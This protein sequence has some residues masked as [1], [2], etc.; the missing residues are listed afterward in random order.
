MCDLYANTYRNEIADSISKFIGPKASPTVWNRTTL[1]SEDARALLDGIARNVDTELF[2]EAC[3]ETQHRAPP[4]VLWE[5][6]P[7]DGA[8]AGGLLTLRVHAVDVDGNK[9]PTVAFRDYPD[10]D[11]DPKND[12]ATTAIDTR[13]VTIGSDDTLPVVVIAT[14]AAGNMTTSTRTFQI[15]NKPPSVTLDSTGLFVDA[16][17]VWWTA[18]PGPTLHGTVSDM[19][20]GM[21]Q[22]EIGG[23][24]VATAVI[25]G[26][27][28][29]AELP[30]DA[31][32][33]ADNDVT[34]VA[35]DAAGN[36]ATKIQTI[37]LD[38][39]P[40]AISV[41]PSP[42]FDET[43]ST[44]NPVD[45]A[46]FFM[47]HVPH[48]NPVDLATTGT[49]PTVAKHA[50]LLFAPNSD[51][52][53]AV[54]GSSGA[55]NPLRINVV[56]SDDGVG[57]K[58]NSLQYRVL[59]HDGDS[60]TE[61]FPWAA[62]P[63]AS[64]SSHPIQLFRDAIPQLTSTNGEY[65]LQ[66]QATD[67]FGRQTTAERCWN[68]IILAPPLLETSSSSGG[69]KATGFQR[70]LWSTRL[71]PGM[72]ET[73]DFAEKF[74]N[75]NAAGAAVW[76]TRFKNYLGLDVYVKVQIPIPAGGFSAS[77]SR[78]FQIMN[79]L[80]N[81]R[82]I[83]HPQLCINGDCMVQS[84]Q[85]LYDSDTTTTQT[86]LRFQ[87]HLFAMIGNET[88]AEIAICP[89]CTSDDTT[90]TYVFKIPARSASQGPLEYGFLTYLVATAPPNGGT[91]IFMAPSDGNQPDQDPGPYTEFPFGQVTLTGKLGPPYNPN[92]QSCAAEGDDGFGHPVC[93]QWASHQIYRAL[94]SIQY[95]F[96]V[97]LVTSYFSSAGTSLPFNPVATGTLPTFQALL[98]TTEVP[99]P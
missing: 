26:N 38:T 36:V 69:E 18:T 15:D 32:S 35:T 61:V 8:L 72:G 81:F 85:V 62:M 71:N 75:G 66:L 79:S 14:G 17:N 52:S 21:V 42:V 88:G 65:H 27:N 70:A 68:H 90:Q 24:V 54:L 45:N 98:E 60:E 30:P 99:L 11:G 40:P 92:E 96:T 55:L 2:S 28:W 64:G 1:G 3:V 63:P 53:H 89:G 94:V 46:G 5:V 67:Q 73:G 93:V 51:G 37:R 31:L 41:D 77:V 48:G 57:L 29:T 78:R 47:E 58:P 16:N 44:F 91:N 4:S 12:V 82:A 25:N 86:G 50:Q 9:L 20:Q 56:V 39:T 34:I 80:T 87:G 19:H 74:L 33:A 95:Q 22:V 84:S 59:L 10:S 76:R 83:Q 43:I 6:S 23:V 13:S 49:C 7:P 97:N